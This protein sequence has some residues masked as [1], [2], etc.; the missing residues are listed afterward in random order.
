METADELIAPD[1]ISHDP[2]LPEPTRGPQGVKEAAGGY[3]AGFPDLTLRIETQVAE[4]DWVCT[5][6][7]AVGTNSGEFWGMAADGQ[8]GD[9]DGDHDRPD[10]RRSHRRVVD[11]LGCSRADAAAR[12]GAGRDAG[13]TM[14]SR[15]AAR[16]PSP[17]STLL[18]MTRTRIHAS[19]QRCSLS[20]N[21]GTSLVPTV[22]SPWHASRSARTCATKSAGWTTR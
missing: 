11:E 12:R 16:R 9:R 4:G 14:P 18:P 5:R 8:A 7:T 6:W 21:P 15:A 20:R 17:F 3:R 13:L 19:R 10:R 22:D 1:A 2:A